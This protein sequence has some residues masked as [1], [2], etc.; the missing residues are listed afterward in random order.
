VKYVAPVDI[1]QGERPKVG[2]VGDGSP[3]VIHDALCRCNHHTHYG[4]NDHQR[5]TCAYCDCSLIEA[6]RKD[7]RGKVVDGRAL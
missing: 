2:F 1:G 3:V 7:E 4:E 5:S 6:V